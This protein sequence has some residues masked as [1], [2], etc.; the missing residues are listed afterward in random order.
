MT[1]GLC[2]SCG[3]PVTVA[4]NGRVLTP[5]PVSMGVFDPT[6]GEPLT[7]QQAAELQRQHGTAGHTTH[8]CP[9]GQGQLF[10]SKEA[11]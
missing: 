6:D 10:D 8:H 2:T 9:I 7:R 5:H 1:T 4:Q 3:D 11:V